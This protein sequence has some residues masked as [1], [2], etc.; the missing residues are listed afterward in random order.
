MGRWKNGPGFSR[1]P[2]HGISE[3]LSPR[4]R[5][6]LSGWALPFSMRLLRSH[7]AG[8]DGALQEYCLSHQFLSAP[9]PLNINS[10]R[11]WTLRP[12]SLPR[13]LGKVASSPLGSTTLHSPARSPPPPVLAEAALSGELGLVGAQHSSCRMLIL[14][15]KSNINPG[16][17]LCLI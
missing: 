11:P 13:Y 16:D 14:Q 6:I 5:D 10:E 7:Q 8:K 9:S 1:S 4:A 17:S 3:T 12:E 15:T 2:R